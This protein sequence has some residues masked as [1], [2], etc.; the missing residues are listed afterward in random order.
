MRLIQRS[1]AHL[2][3]HERINNSHAHPMSGASYTLYLLLMLV[4]CGFMCEHVCMVWDVYAC[5]HMWKKKEICIFAFISFSVF[6][7]I[8]THSTSNTLTAS[9]YLLSFFFVR[10]F[11]VSHSL[12]HGFYTH[13]KCCDLWQF[14]IP[15][16]HRV[17]LFRRVLFFLQKIFRLKWIEDKFIGMWS[18][19]DWLREKKQQQ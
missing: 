9:K 12:I 13:L 8:F 6:A 16:S 3:T 14:R 15:L 1:F 2:W 18:I 11:H 17:S 7:I 19:F 4:A 10:Q 5:V